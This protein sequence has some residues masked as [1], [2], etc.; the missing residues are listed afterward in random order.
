MNILY[1]NEI[2]LIQK[3]GGATRYFYEL[4]K[5]M[6]DY[7]DAEI[8]LYMGYFI[9][10]YGLEKYAD[11]FKHFKGKEIPSIPKTKLISRK[12]QYHTFLKFRE[13]FDFD[14]FH[15]T[16]FNPYEQK[17]C[18]KKIITIHDFTH[19]KYPEYFTGIDKTR[20]EKKKSAETSDGIICISEST[21][22]DLL[23]YYNIPES[24]IKVIY[25]GNSLTAVPGERNINKP[26]LLY[27]GDRRAYKNFEIMLKVFSVDETLKKE[28]I[29]VCFGGGEFTKTEK[30][31]I[32]EY[33][34]SEIVQQVSGTDDKLA[35]MYKYAEAFVY[36]SFY[37]GFGIPLLEAMQYECPIVASDTNSLREV[38]GN[39]AVYFEPQST[40]SLI[41][42]IKKVLYS[43]E[44]KAEIITNGRERI[45]LFSWDKCAK[46]TYN[47]YK[48]LI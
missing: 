33:G 9:N 14:V 23:E 35:T 32:I 43:S 28:F 47:F 7:K 16:Y 45:K 22:N 8:S 3:Y 5:R 10:K 6:L 13:R 2:F 41:E 12:L 29:L 18:E 48:E 21:K 40:D 11:R 37:E 34:L 4:I 15:Q 31:K 44:K 17:K 30:R 38:G 42:A 46:E 26:Y 1:D 20:I 24:R 19:E 36:P 25:H 39:A 27:V